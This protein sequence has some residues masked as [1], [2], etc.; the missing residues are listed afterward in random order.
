MRIA[1]EEGMGQ[2]A[3]MSEAKF[4]SDILLCEVNGKQEMAAGFT[5]KEGGGGGGLWTRLTSY[6]H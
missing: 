1:P 4:W 2:G 3:Y 6:R 5:P